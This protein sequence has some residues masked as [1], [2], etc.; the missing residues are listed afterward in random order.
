MF[1]RTI[2]PLVAEASNTSAAA[3]KRVLSV[4]APIPP[5]TALSTVRPALQSTYAAL[6]VSP[7]EI[8]T[9][10]ATQALNCPRATSAAGAPVAAAAGSLLM[11]LLAVL[12]ALV[13]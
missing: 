10:G 9:Y 11:G 8:G 12:L 1:F 7:D 4:G 5:G 2:E 13:L 3:I 6:R